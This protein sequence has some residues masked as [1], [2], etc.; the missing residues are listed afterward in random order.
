MDYTGGFGSHHER[1]R[2]TDSLSKLR[3][4]IREERHA[5]NRTVRTVRGTSDS[6]S[7]RRTKTDPAWKEIFRDTSRET[8]RDVSAKSSK[9]DSKDQPKRRSADAKEIFKKVPKKVSAPV[10]GTSQDTHRFVPISANDEDMYV[11]YD[12]DEYVPSGQA[13]IERHSGEWEDFTLPDSPEVVPDRATSPEVVPSIVDAIVKHTAEPVTDRVPDSRN[14][15]YRLTSLILSTTQNSI[16]TAENNYIVRFGTGIAEGGG[17]EADELGTTISFLEDGSY[18]F[19]IGGDAAP[20]SD[21]DVDLVFESE[22]FTDDLKPFTVTHVPKDEGKL[23]LRGL[24]TI[25]PLQ[26]GDKVT[27]RLVPSRPENI[28]LLAH[29]R[30]LIY[31]VA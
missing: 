25:L 17:I 14:C 16:L 5:K 31:R 12:P 15:N 10:P 19:E 6:R 7:T 2:H 1:S 23:Q 30:L 24:S 9:K 8:P 21:V 22:L 11:F 27:V 13:G 28:A 4:L 29:T 26:A 18:R 3:G 20:F